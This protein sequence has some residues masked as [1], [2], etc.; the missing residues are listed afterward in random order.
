MVSDYGAQIV[1][2]LAAPAPADRMIEV[3]S[4]RGTKTLL[5]AGHTRRSG[6]AAR[7]WALDAHAYKTHLA[8]ARLEK[9]RVEGVCQLSGDARNLDAF[10]DLPPRFE[11]VLID[12]PCSGTGTLRRHPEIAWSLTEA[13][14][15]SCAALQLELLR[16]CAMRVAAGGVMTYATCSVLREENEDVVRAFLDGPEGADF[17]LA[18]P[19]DVVA[20]PL[21]RTACGEI[22]E[23]TT[24]EGC[25]RTY[26]APEQ[27]DGHFCA[28]LVRR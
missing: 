4:G 24:D 19:V 8:A 1:A 2:C 10:P 16:S 28:Q 13:D 17:K 9:A 27:C 22:A 11:R 18:A 6:G 15:A 12:A 3:G 20:G 26:P 14:V 5:L 25:M 23:R 21:G 7:V